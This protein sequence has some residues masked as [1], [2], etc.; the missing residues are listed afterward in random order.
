MTSRLQHHISWLTTWS[1]TS[2][3]L[4]VIAAVS[5]DEAYR[6]F[7]DLWYIT[8]LMLISG[9]SIMIPSLV[10]YFGLSL[11]GHEDGESSSSSSKLDYAGLINLTPLAIIFYI[12]QSYL[13]E[14][15]SVQVLDYV[16]LLEV[17]FGVGI[18]L[19]VYSLGY[20]LERA[21]VSGWR[22]YS[23]LSRVLLISGALGA[24]SVGPVAYALLP[25]HYTLARGCGLWITASCVPILIRQAL[26][27]WRPLGHAAHRQIV[28]SYAIL[29]LACGVTLGQADQKSI[30]RSLYR[31]SLIRALVESIPLQSRW[32]PQYQQLDQIASPEQR[33]SWHSDFETRFHRETS[34]E[35]L[36]ETSK[37]RSN[38]QGQTQAP[39]NVIVVI[40]ESVRWDLW[41]RPEISPRFHSWRKHGLYVPNAVAQYPATPLAYAALFL[42]QTPSVV[43][44]STHWMDHRPLDLLRTVFPKMYLSRPN[45]RWFDDEAITGFMTD[46]QHFVEHRSARKALRGLK[47]FVE[48]QLE[49]SPRDQQSKEQSKEQSKQ[50]RPFFA[51]VHLYEPHRPWLKHSR[52]MKPAFTYDQSKSDEDYVKYTEAEKAKRGKSK[53]RETSQKKRKREKKGKRKQRLSKHVKKYYSE[54]RYVDDRLGEFMEWFYEQEISENTLVWVMADHG[55]GLGE[56]IDKKRF[57][58]HHVHV[59]NQISWVPFY[60]SGP[61]IARDQVSYTLP[62]SQ[63][64]LMPTIFD[65][66][67]QE[68]P[69]QLYAQGRSLYE[70]LESPQQERAIPTEAFSIR[71]KELFRMLR[72]SRTADQYI[73]QKIQNQI[74]N[75]G[76]YPPKLG[77]QIGPYKVIYNRLLDQA[78]YYN[79]SRDL[80]EQRPLRLSAA[81][82]EELLHHVVRWET[83]QKWIVQQTQTR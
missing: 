45:N 48:D 32:L 33:A 59:H 78:R 53:K 37:A 63:L 22:R 72:E 42:S 8:S 66:V 38:E 49:P 75:Y 47:A 5:L 36:K 24:L 28:V 81:K 51:W 2:A 10:V 18:P 16:W 9:F 12:L 82:R 25:D 14:G 61:H 13:L 62:V 40:L 26:T 50:K 11:R 39:L 77:L 64:D 34:R 21:R 68:L 83:M 71:G 30:R 76:K 29:L 27:R 41:S 57:I 55:Q 3:V 60:A 20:H 7:T 4:L 23:L 58:G 54:L 35:A 70:T 31:H 69:P 65:H 73:S 1:S 79:T 52:F 19:G 44:Q 80:Q 43:T 6:D 56:R 46:P 67:G 17:G 15:Y 74:V